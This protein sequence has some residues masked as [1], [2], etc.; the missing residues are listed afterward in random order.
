MNFT[1]EKKFNLAL[2]CLGLQLLMWI[3]GYLFPLFPYVGE[4]GLH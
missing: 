3:I 2:I 1:L 4:G